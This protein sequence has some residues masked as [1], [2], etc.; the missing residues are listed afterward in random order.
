MQDGYLRT[1]EGKPQGD[2]RMII[3]RKMGKEIGRFSSIT[4][5]AE[6]YGLTF[7]TVK[8][9]LKNGKAYRNMT[10]ETQEKYNTKIACIKQ[11]K[12][13]VANGLYGA[14]VLCDVPE[15]IIRDAIVLGTEEN[16]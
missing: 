13:V 10:F 5:A 2:T 16:G 12:V 8:I 9:Y 6:A 14:S 4:R 3:V 1:D 7:K 11:G 15:V